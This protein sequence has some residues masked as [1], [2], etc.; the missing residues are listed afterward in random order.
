MRM[1]REACEDFF[2]KN[3]RYHFA[4]MTT[5]KGMVPLEQPVGMAEIEVDSR[6]CHPDHFGKAQDKFHEGTR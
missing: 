3:P 1:K 6:H 5:G 4:G 2:G